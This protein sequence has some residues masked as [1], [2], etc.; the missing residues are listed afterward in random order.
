MMNTGD[1]LFPKLAHCVVYICLHVTFIFIVP[2]RE[3]DPVSLISGYFFIVGCNVSEKLVDSSRC[4]SNSL[5]AT[6]L[7]T[8]HIV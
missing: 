1:F 3:G 4:G 7:S 8:T 2:G 5:A 6:Y